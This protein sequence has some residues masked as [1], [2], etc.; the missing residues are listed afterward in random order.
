MTAQKIDTKKGKK[1]KHEAKKPVAESSTARRHIAVIGVA[2][3]LAVVGYANATKGSFVYDDEYQIVKNPL[4][5]PGGNIVQAFSSD[6]WQFRSGSGE[7]RSNY[8]RPLF[9]GWLALNYRL[10]GLNPTGWHLMN[11]LLH[12]LATLLGYRLLLSMLASPTAAAIA[13]WI[14]AVHP[15]HI[16]SITWISGSTDLLMAI[17]L[18][19]SMIAYLASLKT[20][21][22]AFRGGAVIL[23]FFALLSK[24]A[25][26]S[27]IAVL[28]FT[29]LILS[30]K[31]HRSIKLLLPTTLK[32]LLPF[33]VTAVVF[34][35]LRY[36]ILH[37][38]RELAPGAPD[39]GSVILTIPSMLI[40]YFRQTFLPFEFGPV[41]GVRYVNSTNIGFLNFLLPLTL[42]AV[43]A[44]AAGWLY[45]RGTA[46]RI[47]LFWFVLPLT[48]VLDPRIFVPEL[49]VQ[50][51]Y[52]YIPIFGA[53]ILIAA[54][55]IDLT[56]L[57]FRD[58][59]RKAEL[60]AVSAALVICVGL[61]LVTV[62]FN[63]VWANGMAL[64]EQG[65]KVDP[66]SALAN[67]QLANEYQRVG[68]L[69]EAKEAVSR[70]IQ[71]R[72]EMTN[73]YLTRGIISVRERRFE[74]AEADLR[75]V[76]NTFPALEVPR[77]QLAL[78]YQLQGRLDESIALFEEGRRLIPAKQSIYTI[79]IAVLHKLAH[80]D[81]E[82]LSNLESLIP[83]LNTTS[84]PD[85]L[86]GWFYLGELY[87]EQ[88][89]LENAASAY[90]RYLK[91]S[92]SGAD[93]KNLREQAIQRLQQIR[94]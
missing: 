30:Q 34:V 16:Q 73:A 44:F 85:V 58:H 9:V 14:F 23:F 1:A 46:Y 37:A 17:F 35:V 25:A 4:I 41:Y 24:E 86:A 31:A 26:I 59:A 20:T 89:R 13:T 82:A 93:A 21:G 18:F 15:A 76:L 48:L 77:E 67:V 11:I 60:V 80:R 27:F 57:A 28:F 84:D 10:F 38:M 87:R 51:R 66:S 53:A 74:D 12:C 91:A 62:S 22:W 56:A 55:V 64:W 88:G 83:V 72:P 6:V 68:R 2:L 32:R 49:L 19:G 36:A 39:L 61:D 43:L 7:T 90:D 40:F 33:A 5:K 42:I 65:V 54:G 69:Q 79:N 92:E 63:P 81:A 45:K 8:W 70:A 50:D 3:L 29:D 52:L 94:K 71:I 75:R 78:A 47:G